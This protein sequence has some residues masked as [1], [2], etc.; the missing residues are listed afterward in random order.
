M[1][2]VVNILQNEASGNMKRYY[3]LICSTLILFITLE[4]GDC[5]DINAVIFY[6][7]IIYL[8]NY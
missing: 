3:V 4:T 6:N 1:L 5:Y 7:V 2:K 8:I